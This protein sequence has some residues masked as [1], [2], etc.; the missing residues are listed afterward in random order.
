[1]AKTKKVAKT[2]YSSQSATRSVHACTQDTEKGRSGVVVKVVS[3][4]AFV[5]ELGNKALEGVFMCLVVEFKYSTIKRIIKR[6]FSVDI[7][8]IVSCQ[9]H[10][11]L[12][13]KKHIYINNFEYLFILRI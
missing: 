11:N 8:K 12:N 3:L 7:V 2:K 6:L 1:M 5:H 9:T 10:M 13:G 4:A